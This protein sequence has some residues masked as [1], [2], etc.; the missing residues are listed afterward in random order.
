MSGLFFSALHGGDS[1]QGRKTPRDCGREGEKR[2]SSPRGRSRG[3]FGPN[4]RGS[5]GGL[6]AGG[7]LE[8]LQHY[9]FG[10]TAL[11][12]A[13]PE[14]AG[15]RPLCRRGVHCEIE[16]RGVVSRLSSSERDIAM[17]GHHTWLLMVF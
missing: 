1:G 16:G 15:S 8:Y 4:Q 13:L 11:G 6:A 3:A 14:R 17:K 7:P 10:G 9:L 5:E 2:R 12:R